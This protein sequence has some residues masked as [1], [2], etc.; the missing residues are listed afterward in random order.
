M[1]PRSKRD[2]FEHQ[3]HLCKIRADITNAAFAP[4]GV[5]DVTLAKRSR[6]FQGP[7]AKEPGT[8]VARYTCTQ[9]GTIHLVCGFWPFLRHSERL[10]SLIGCIPVP[11]ITGS[12]ACAFL[13]LRLFND[14]VKKRLLSSTVHCTQAL[15]LAMVL[16]NCHD[17]EKARSKD[18]PFRKQTIFWSH[19]SCHCGKRMQ[20]LMVYHKIG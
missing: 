4:L 6:K 14:R 13:W 9:L 7:T 8:L 16:Q 15:E 11:D 18:S 1:H 20:N 2:L 5:C 3:S 17:S 10:G 19:T 12:N